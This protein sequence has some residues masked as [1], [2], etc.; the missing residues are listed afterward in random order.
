[1]IR[2]IRSLNSINK[3]TFKE[4]IIESTLFLNA[5]FAIVILFF[6]LFFLFKE[7][8]PI[9]EKIGLLEFL[10]GNI[11]NPAGDPPSYGAFPL[12]LG[13]LLVTFGAII[14]SVPLGIGSA[15]F[16]SEIAPSKIKIIIKSGVEIL[17]GIPSVVYG[18]FGLVVLADWLRVTFNKPSGECWLAGSIILGIMA[19][20]TIISVSEDAISSVPREY[21]EASLSL[22][23]TKW[24]TIIKVIVPSALSGIIGAI[25]LG[26]GRVIGET[27]AVMMV[28]GNAAI[29]PKPITNVFAPIRTI[30]STLGIEMGEVAYEST[31][32]H[33]LFGLA[34]ILFTITLVVTMTA[35]VILGKLKEKHISTLKKKKRKMLSQKTMR[36]VKCGIYALI[37]LITVWLLIVWL[38]I[39]IALLIIFIVLC[40]YFITKKVS[41]RIP[42]ISQ[43]VAFGIVTL[44]AII[45]LF[46][47]GLILYY[48]IAKGI[49]A[50]SWEF[51][52]QF[53][54]D[55]GRAGGI[56]P[57]IIGTLYLVSG[58]IL[59]ALPIGIGAAICL[60]EYTREGLMTKIIRTGIESLN[61][62]PSIVF[63]LFGF[64]FLVLYLNMGI[65]LLAGQITLAPMILPTIIRTTEE[66]LK[67]VPQSM[68][69]ASLA[70]GAT[71][72]QTVRKVVLPSAMPG[73]ITGSILSIGRAAGETAPIMFTAVVFS[74]RFLPISS[75]EPVMA[76]PYHLFVLA[77]SVP[78]AE[79]NAYGTALVLL[80]L[81]LCLYLIA[82]MIRLHY[83]KVMKWW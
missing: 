50:L 32:Y 77:T 69:E 46:M 78:N 45:V 70:L 48:I 5:I 21:K 65:S 52:S 41:V 37:G 66:S 58:A 35:N 17:A 30:T 83:K 39:Q 72:W 33:A 59:I 36:M 34:L 22:G 20:P 4:N 19:L 43:G 75:L 18:F 12:I 71:K 60:T 74:Q 82:I 14:I 7:G 25:I 3:K 73:I 68:R 27:M 9:L 26:I 13:T 23:A 55:S 10:S 47:L 31:H 2:K 40:C 63:G 51:L 61:G 80:I 42:R 8:Y 53:P 62:T 16:I 57:A 11:W 15:I 79:Q 38:N 54:K 67:S 28:T 1:M 29:I 76:L 24:Q 81:V 6:I 64:S 44:S 56:Y 49:G